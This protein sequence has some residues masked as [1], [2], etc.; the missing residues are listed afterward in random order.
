MLRGGGRSLRSRI[1]IRP[2][3]LQLDWGALTVTPLPLVLL[4]TLGGH[5]APRDWPVK[6]EH[7]RRRPAAYDGH[8]GRLSPACHPG[9]LAQNPVVPVDPSRLLGAHQH[10][11]VAFRVANPCSL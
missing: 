11:A 2:P 6:D 4:L 3:L 9:I 10:V 5:G 7:D 8:V 1:G